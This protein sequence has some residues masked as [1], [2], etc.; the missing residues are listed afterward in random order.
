MKIKELKKKIK[1]VFKPPKK[2]YYFGKLKY[3]TPY[4]N[5]IG[6]NPKIF[7]FRKL[8]INN[9]NEK[10]LR[11]RFSNMPM[12]LRNKYKIIK[13][14]NNY[15]YF[16]YALPFKIKSVHLGWKDKFNLPRFEW[17]PMFQIYFF[18]LQFCIIWVSPDKKDYDNE[19]YFEM[20]LHYLYYSDNDIKKAK[21]TWGWVDNN[22][23][24]TWNDFYLINQ[25]K[26]KI[27]NLLKIYKK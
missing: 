14:F 9:L 12:N 2:I 26:I 13:M 6:F 5:P 17:N 7:S 11:N 24:S 18:N 23:Q 3:G 4:F 25:R 10:Q 15:Y 21:K 22:K 19:L 20:I 27:D 1:G 16:S 8:I